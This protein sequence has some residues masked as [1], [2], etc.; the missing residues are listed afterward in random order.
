LGYTLIFSLDRERTWN[1]SCAAERNGAAAALNVNTLGRRE[2]EEYF[3][4]S[5]IAV[6]LVAALGTL[7]GLLPVVCFLRHTVAAVLS[8]SIVVITIAASL[9]SKMPRGRGSETAALS[10]LQLH[11]LGVESRRP[12]FGELILAT[13]AATF[14]P[15]T[16]GV[17]TLLIYGLAY[18]AGQLVRFLLH[19]F[20]LIAHLPPETIA[21][22]PAFF[23]L[24][25]FG[26]ASIAMVISQIRKTL[27]PDTPGGRSAYYGI[28]AKGRAEVAMRVLIVAV[29]IIVLVL[30]AE[31][32][33][34]TWPYVVLQIWLFFTVSPT[35]L[36]GT[37][38][39]Q[40][41]KSQK[42]VESIGNLLKACDYHVT[43]EPS[44]RS[45]EDLGPLLSTVDLIAEGPRGAFAIE[46]K[47]DSR[48]V[49]ESMD[50]MQA[51]NLQTAAWGLRRYRERLGIQSEV[52]WPVLIFIGRE[53]DPN[54][55]EFCRRNEI[56]VIEIDEQLFLRIQTGDADT[57][58]QIAQELVGRLEVEWMEI[59]S[60][61]VTSSSTSTA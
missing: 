50:R 6:A 17:L 14:P 8:L 11:M 21:F 9:F 4:P 28:V 47:H 7:V 46:I 61:R 23:V 39:R 25:L 57:L 51:S 3:Q 27:F 2:T 26:L 52:L 55:R 34:A 1:L 45:T 35:W 40:P 16:A 41:L 49:S 53:A 54:L 36:T 32:Y 43:F 33:M 30:S 56:V 38:V 42:V 13:V 24:A 12:T 15:A 37:R 10:A 22:Y 20:G 18:W 48:P 29:P 44:S 19:T 58:R 31:V 5:R 59:H 60:P